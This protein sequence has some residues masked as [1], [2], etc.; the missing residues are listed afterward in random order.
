MARKI[1]I[2]MTGLRYGRLIG[3]EFSHR[4]GSHAH[5]RFL[6][7]CG[8]ETT[9]DGTAVR[10]GKTASC[11]CLHREIC[12]ERLTTHGRRAK[13]RHDPTYRAWQ[14]INTFC[15]NRESSRYRD[16]G[17]RGI[18]VCPAWSKDFQAFLAD[19]GERPA[20][21]ILVLIDP[22]QDFAPGNCRWALVRSR[23]R[24]ARDGA[25]RRLEEIGAT[26]A[27]AVS[28]ERIAMI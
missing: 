19:L 17:A 27:W 11:G 5:W 23:S 16:F 24:R 8:N 15:T 7:D 3:I 1:R 22:R 18:R 13:K 9:V 4:A 10:A 25:K 28:P 6:C 2:D 26:P 14:E 12:A 21:R 20:G